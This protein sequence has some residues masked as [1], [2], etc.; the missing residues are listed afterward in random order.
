MKNLKD[1]SS[2][3]EWIGQM[4]DIVANHGLWKI[5]K[6]TIALAF[7][8]IL[9]NI[10]FNPEMIFDKFTQYTEQKEQAISEHRT[11]VDP[12]I[13]DELH[14]LL[15]KTNSDR[16]YIMEFHNGKSNRA[17][18]GFLYAEMTYEETKIDVKQLSP[19]FKEINLSLLSITDELYRNGYWYGTLEDLK[20][21]DPNLGA[22]LEKYGDRW[23]AMLLLEGSS[24]LGFLCIS[25][26]NI[27]DLTTQ[28]FIG[29]EIRKTAV[30]IGAML[31]YSKIK[32]KIN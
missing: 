32:I 1:A 31:D 6:G 18:L 5:I 29:R 27:P 26:T 24:P 21:I 2:F 14:K 16:T 10:S 20:K 12:L 3:I 23:I 13:R 11:M 7:A 17:S 30:S 15:L 8:L 28:Q 9:L 25:T 19:Y 22:S 4:A